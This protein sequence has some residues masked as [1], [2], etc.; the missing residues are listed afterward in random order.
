MPVE[1]IENIKGKYIVNKEFWNKMRNICFHR[2]KV[3][4]PGRINEKV[5]NVIKSN[6]IKCNVAEYKLEDRIFG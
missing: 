1:R 6:C 4:I 2:E 5:E 3:K